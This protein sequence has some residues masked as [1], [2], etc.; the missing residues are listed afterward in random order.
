VEENNQKDNNYDP[1]NDQALNQLRNSETN[2][3][4]ESEHTG[5]EQPATPQGY[6]QSEGNTAGTESQYGQYQQPQ[7]QGGQGNT[8]NYYQNTQNPYGQYQYNQNQNN[9][10]QYNQNQYNQNPYNQYQNQNS[11]Q[12]NPYQQ[13]QYQ[14]PTPP[15]NN[16]MA[17]A[18]LVCGII[19]ILLSCCYYLS[20]PLAIIS[21]ILGILVLKNHKDGRPLAIVGIVLG[22]ITILISLI[23][24]LVSI[25]VFNSMAGNGYDIFQEYNKIFNGEVPNVY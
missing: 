6:Q 19:G 4:A 3:T 25:Y 13:Y 1:F 11:Y 8:D 16:G 5:N 2:G 22:A 23:F 18:S 21:V 9:S 14:E 10:T 20:L 24:V 7:Y 17:I 12:Q 15:K